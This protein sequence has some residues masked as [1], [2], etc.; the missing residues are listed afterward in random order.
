MR[1]RESPLAAIERCASSSR[2]ICTSGTS[3]V[4]GICIR[5]VQSDS[6]AVAATSLSAL[7]ISQ[8]TFSTIF[9]SCLPS[10]TVTY[11]KVRIAC[12]ESCSS[13]S[14][15][16]PKH[17]GPRAVLYPATSR[18]N[19]RASVPRARQSVA[20]CCDEYLSSA[21]SVTS[22]VKAKCGCCRPIAMMI[23]ATSGRSSASASFCFFLSFGKSSSTIFF[24]SDVNASMSVRTNELGRQRRYSC[25]C[26]VH[27]ARFSAF[28]APS[29]SLGTSGSRLRSV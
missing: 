26:L 29:S 19:S 9:F 28:L 23:D 10:G 13:A 3:S 25:S 5:Y 16:K 20:F 21:S 27:S 14:D 17:S 24:E 7:T 2:K 12:D 18:G 22:S 1:R 11:G 4:S 8:M 15:M 6:K